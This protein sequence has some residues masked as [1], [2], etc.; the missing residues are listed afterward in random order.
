[1]AA[2]AVY[3]TERLA[4]TPVGGAP[5]RSGFVVNIH[6][7][8][9]QVYARERYVLNGALPNTTYQIN[10]LA[11]LNDPTCTTLPAILP[12]ATLQTN[13]AGNGTAQ[14]VFSPEDVTGFP[15]ATHCIAW[16]V[17][18][19]NGAVVYRTECTAVTLD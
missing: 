11:H 18:T 6:A 12:T 16:T 5:L 10:L 19:L 15:K 8:G 7:N 9:P 3:H 13:Q 2:D 14:V 17:M 1:M 4:F